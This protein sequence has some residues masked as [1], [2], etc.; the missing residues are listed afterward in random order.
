M[1]VIAP[2]ATPAATPARTSPSDLASQAPSTAHPA[3]VVTAESALL[4]STVG[5]PGSSRCQLRAKATYS[6]APGG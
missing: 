1:L 2:A 4:A 3:A 6:G 5:T